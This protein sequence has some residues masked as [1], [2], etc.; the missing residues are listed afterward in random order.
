GRG[1]ARGS[2]A[3]LLRRR[4]LRRRL[5]AYRFG[6][7]HRAPRRDHAL[8]RG[9]ASH[10]AAAHGVNRAATRRGVS[11]RRAERACRNPL[12]PQLARGR[13]R[14]LVVGWRRASRDPRAK[15]T[16]APP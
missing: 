5:R 11:R 6:L 9:H 7:A 2:L 8:V 4:A 16:A 15:S 10:G 12:T 3:L 14:T 1:N 13:I